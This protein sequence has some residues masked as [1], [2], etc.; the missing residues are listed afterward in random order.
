MF[1]KEDREVE[2]KESEKLTSREAQ[3]RHGII[4]RT[5]AL[6]WCCGTFMHLN[7]FSCRCCRAHLLMLLERKQI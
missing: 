2:Q 3:R 5:E 6:Q 4:N 1:F 7:V